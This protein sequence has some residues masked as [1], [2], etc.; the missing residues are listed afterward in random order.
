LGAAVK[1]VGTNMQYGGSALQQRAPIPNT[2]PGSRTGMYEVVTEAF[3]L[4]SYFELALGYKFDMNEQN[5]LQVASTFRSNNALEDQLK[6]G[7]EYGFNNM[8]FVRGGYDLLLENTNQNTFGLTA[9]AGVN[10]QMADGINLTL[11]YAFREVKEFASANHII[12]LKLGI[13]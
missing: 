3:Q 10:Y 8:F 2:L 5:M 1:N 9:G 12:T 4:P 13:Q 7:L 6:L 11:D